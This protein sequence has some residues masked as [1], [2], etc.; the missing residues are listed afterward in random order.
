MDIHFKENKKLNFDKVV[1][2]FFKVGFLKRKN[3]KEKYKKAI[4][5]AFLNSDY[6]VSAWDKDKLIGFARVLTDKSLFATIWNMIV[7]PKY[8]NKGV[9]KK[10]MQKCLDKYPKCHFFL[11][12]DE[13]V[14]G[15]Y[16]KAGFNLHPHG[17]YLEKGKKVCAIYN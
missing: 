13:K 7:R 1:G 4:K 14:S 2:I 3:K 17:M 6:V 11:I 5:R 9:G 10:L 15:F 8:Q 16:K 12:A